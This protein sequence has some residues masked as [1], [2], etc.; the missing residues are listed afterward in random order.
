MM[1]LRVQSAVWVAVAVLSL[2]VAGCEQGVEVQPASTPVPPATP[3]PPNTPV[4]PVASLTPAAPVLPPTPTLEERRM[5]VG[6]NFGNNT[7]VLDGDLH[8]WYI[9]CPPTPPATWVAPMILSDLVSGSHVYLDRNGV[10]KESPEPVYL[11]EEGQA[12]L[13][14]VLKDDSIVKQIVARPEC[15]E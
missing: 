14:A 7:R 10:V 3:M 13:E 6:T 9:P 2:M 8:V 5:P 1:T 11:T 15:P 12:K 4:P